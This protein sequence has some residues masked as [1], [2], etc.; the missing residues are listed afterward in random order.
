M[1]LLNTKMKEDK[2]EAI[3]T[4]TD[5]CAPDQEILV[6]SDDLFLVIKSF[7]KVGFLQICQEICYY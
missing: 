1:P 6:T 4:S 3:A 7:K 2:S 5:L